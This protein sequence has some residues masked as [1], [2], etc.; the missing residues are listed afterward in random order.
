MTKTYNE[1]N[2]K[3]K[4]GDVVVVTAEE[5]IK[6]VE[7]QGI[8]VAA[9]EIDVVTTGTFGPMCSSGAFLNFGHSDPPIKFEHL[10]LNDV[11]AYHGNAAVDCYIGCTRMSDIHKYEYGGGHVIEDLVSKKPIRL[12]GNSY[13]TDCYPLAEVNTEFTID[14]INQAILCNPRNAYQRYVCAVNSSDKTL[15]TYMGK[16]L[17]YF[18]NAH[19][20]GTGCLNPLSNDPDYET[21]GIGT[22]IFLGGGIG[23]VVGEGSQHNPRDRFGTLFLKG[24][25][26][27]MCSEFLR[28]VCYEKYGTSMFVGVGV[29]IPILNEGLARKTSIRDEE[30]LT[31]V[32]DYGV[33]RRDRPKLKEISY[34]ELKSGH[35]DL[36]GKKVKSSSLSSLFYARKIAEILKKWIVSGK[37]LLNPPAET[38]P[39]NTHF[40][41]MKQTSKL[42][43]VK[44]I[45]R[46]AVICF[47]DCDLKMVAKKIINQ[48]M[49]H[50]V[51]TN[52]EKVL[53]GI[54]TSF[55]VT[56]AIAED[57]NALDKI[58]TKKVI[59][60]SNNEPIDVAARKM[61]SN[62][63]SAL[64]V[65]DENNKVVG[66]ITSEEMM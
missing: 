39:T 37:F 3:I 57:K 31:D 42:K 30:L 19:Y 52:R 56:R 12:R 66:I 59:T 65:V 29:P 43:F 18:G 49:N 7:D 35:I 32:V 54:V 46:E 1:I 2:E 33:P 22:R 55:D 16:L 23:Y 17:P 50:I 25:L 27:Q 28:G 51:I 64:P 21:I 14:D 9:E 8:K 40:K 6:V 62:E 60:T 44:D 48:S 41:P 10:W 53:M 61:K 47:D 45:K 24:D 13:T 38:L 58:I 36:D 11:K 4:N 20:A 15:Y 26:K 5:M 63:I 34:K